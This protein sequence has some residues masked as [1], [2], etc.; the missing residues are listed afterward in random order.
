[1]K[2]IIKI[3]ES[4]V[5]KL[6]K[7]EPFNS[8]YQYSLFKNPKEFFDCW[9]FDFEIIPI[10]NLV[11]NEAKSFGGAPGFIILKKDRKVQIISFGQKS[12]IETQEERKIGLNN[13]LIEI[14]TKKWNKILIRKLTGI[15]PIEINEFIEN[16]KPYDFS[17]EKD[18]IAAVQKLEMLIKENNR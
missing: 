12:E 2:E 6:N 3:A 14:V 10:K 9:Y 18:R 16:F 13:R 11:K 5:L 17:N 1:V 4:F 7:E 15:K 8:E